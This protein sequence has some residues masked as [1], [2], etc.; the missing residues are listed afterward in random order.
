MKKDIKD[1][2]RFI[3]E[4]GD[5]T[6]YLKGKKS[7]LGSE[8]V[9]NTFIIR[10]VKISEPLE[11]V[12][13]KIRVLQEKIANNPFYDVPSIR[14]KREKG[15]YYLHATDD[16]PEIRKEFFDLINTISCT[17]EAVV[18]RKSI[19]RFVTRHKEK[20]E[21]FYADM[22]SHLLKDKFTKYEKLVLNISERGQSTKHAN[23]GVA[24]DKAK[25]RFNEKNDPASLKTKM[26]FEVQSPTNEPILNLA[27][28]LCWA[29]QRVFERGETRYYNY[30]KD[31]IKLVIDL[32]DTA[33]IEGQRNHYTNDTNPLTSKNK[34][35]PPIH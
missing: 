7:A 9:S 16:L 27:D 18:G 8:G 19:E 23:L 2:H 15:G 28:Y 22:L 6:F 17:F 30:L 1:Y 14:K 10:M 20:E 26:V 11:G 13:D 12:R 24:L 25:Q 5:T 35:S 3:D 4:A 21:L 32:Y 29:V 31:K 33:N 34:I